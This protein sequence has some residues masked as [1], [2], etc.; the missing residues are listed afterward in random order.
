MNVT[1]SHIVICDDEEIF[2]GSYVGDADCAHDLFEL[3]R[4]AEEHSIRTLWIKAEFYHFANEE[5]KVCDSKTANDDELEY[6]RKHWEDS[7][8][9]DN[10]TWLESKKFLIEYDTDELYYEEDLYEN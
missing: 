10:L 7:E 8:F 3:H 5:S 1:F 6:I 9:N 2:I 4:Y